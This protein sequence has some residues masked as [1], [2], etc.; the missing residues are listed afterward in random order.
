MKEEFVPSVAELPICQKTL[1]RYWRRWPEG[2]HDCS[3]AV[4]SVEPT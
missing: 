4:V 2:P 1:H 3:D